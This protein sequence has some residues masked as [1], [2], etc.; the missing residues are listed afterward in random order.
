MKKARKQPINA[1]TADAAR[2]IPRIS[3]EEMQMPVKARE[4]LRKSLFGAKA[5]ANAMDVVGEGF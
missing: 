4:A 1:T 2:P 5:A 3:Q